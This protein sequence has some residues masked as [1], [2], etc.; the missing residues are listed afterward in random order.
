MHR[1]IL[2]A[3]ALSLGMGVTGTAISRTASAT[4]QGYIS[5]PQTLY[6]NIDHLLNRNRGG[7]QGLGLAEN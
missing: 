1:P 2:T 6:W 7:D 5:S 4:T 3:Q